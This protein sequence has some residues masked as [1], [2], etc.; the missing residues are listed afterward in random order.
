[1]NIIV[2]GIGY[3]AAVILLIVGV[4]VFVTVILHTPNDW[5]YMAADAL[6]QSIDTFMGNMFISGM[7]MVAIFIFSCVMIILGIQY[8]EKKKKK[9]ASPPVA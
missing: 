2:K 7:V 6:D 3:T 1:M 9:N 5:D 8:F 4:A